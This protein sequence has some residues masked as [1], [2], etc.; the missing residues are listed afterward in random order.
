[1]ITDK[2]NWNDL[3]YFVEV[4]HKGRL[5][6]VAKRL[7]VNHTTVA[8]RITALENALEV[9]LFEQDE[10]GYHLTEVGENLLPLAQ[11]MEDISELAKERAQLSGQSLS[12]NIRIGAPDGFGNSFLAEQITEFLIENTGL[13]V[14]LLPVP[15]THNLLKREV[16]LYITFE[17]S[18]NKNIF[19]RKITDYKLYLYTSKKFIEANNIDLKN[20]DEITKA[21]FASYVDDILYTEHLSFNKHIKSNLNNQ[22]Q[23]ST[24][25]AQQQFVANGG[26]VGVLAYYMACKDPRLVPVFTNQYSFTR[27]YW[28]QTPLELRRLASVRKLEKKIMTQARNDLFKFMPEDI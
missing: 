28:L 24:F 18:T 20:I 8:R 7:G 15:L 12:G 26:G 5:L 10:S 21:P 25:N 27:S 11:Q 19:C 3:R 23:S 1:M 13:T 2:L 22:F 6:T 17:E 4:A 16:D 9:K 14:E